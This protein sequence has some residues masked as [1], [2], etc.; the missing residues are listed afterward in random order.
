MSKIVTLL[1]F[2]ESTGAKVRIY[3]IGRRIIKIPRDDF[4][5]VEKQEIAYPY[6]LQQQ[7]W[8]A[9]SITDQTISKEPVIWFLHFPLDET[10]K[11]QQAG[12]DYF[13]HRLFEAAAASNEQNDSQLSADALK[14][15]PHVFKPREDRMAVFHAVLS[16]KLRQPPSRFYDHAREY[17]SGEQGWEQWNFVGFQGIADLVERLQLDGNEQLLCN[18]IEHLPQ[19]PLEA[20]CQCLE[21]Q[22]CPLSIA[23]ALVD[24]CRQELAQTAPSASLLAHLI[25]A[26]SFTKSLTV[27]DRLIKLVMQSELSSQPDIVSAIA[28]RSWEWLS[29]DD[30]TRQYLENL[31]MSDQDTFNYCLSDLLFMPGLR[32]VLLGVIRSPDRSDQLAQ[33]FSNMMKSFT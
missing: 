25:R 33:S 21:N 7:A 20:V 24:R 31:A 8:F 3:D 9:M 29:G 18:A 28:A 22:H 6:P 15:N 23:E 26:V 27:R 17:F 11:L 14:D 4:L 16:H 30:N 5:K 10:G 1:E 32:D 13:I 2:L 12:R 19:Q